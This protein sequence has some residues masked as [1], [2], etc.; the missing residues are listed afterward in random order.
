MQFLSIVFKK[1]MSITIDTNIWPS[2]VGP[3]TILLSSWYLQ[4]HLPPSHTLK[5]TWTYCLSYNEWVISVQILLLMIYETIFMLTF[6]WLQKRE[7]Y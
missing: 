6:G 2:F 3:F 7:Q 4:T 1:D 5:Y